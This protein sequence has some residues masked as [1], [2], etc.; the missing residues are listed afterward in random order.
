MESGN[1]PCGC[2][3]SD[4][5]QGVTR[6]DDLSPAE[7]WRQ[8]DDRHQSLLYRRFFRD[9]WGELASILD[10]HAESRGARGIDLSNALYVLWLTWRNTAVSRMALRGEIPDGEIRRPR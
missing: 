1:L 2:R 9:E 8:L 3:V 6:L 5:H 10:E 4:L 7:L